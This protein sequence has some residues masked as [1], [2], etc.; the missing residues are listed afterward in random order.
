MRY[1]SL[2]NDLF[3][4]RKSSLLAGRMLLVC[5]L[6]LFNF[7]SITA[8]D[9]PKTGKGNGRD[10]TRTLQYEGIERTFHIH[11]P[12]TFTMD[13]HTPMVL[14][15]HGG[16][17][18]GSKFEKSTTSGTLTA[19]ADKQG[20]VVV[21]PEGIDK[22]WFDGRTEIVKKKDRHNDVG[23]ISAIIDIMVKNYNIDP[24]RV[25]S[26]GISNGG[27]MSYRLAMD[28]SDKIAAIAPVAAQVSKAVTGKTPERPISVMVINGT[29][30]PLVPFDG[31]HV[32]LFRFGRSR[33]EVLSTNATVDFF[34]KHNGCTGKQER[35]KLDDTD[36]EDGTSVEVEKYAGCREGTEVV[37]VKVIGGGHTWPGGTQY[38][39]PWLVGKVSK[40]INASE[41]ILDFFLKHSLNSSNH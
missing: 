35:N 11:L 14:A 24:N 22:Q 20:V 10:F 30:D 31:G 19:A 5:L 15:L 25:Y 33:G 34:L 1:I 26:T 12:P 16:G 6:C 7:N 37:L 29:D 3:L 28:L 41:L 36:P 39:K 40:D 4:H 21:F 8:K 18:K 9:A 27:F 17:G 38:L 13:K 23:F 32:R 2:I